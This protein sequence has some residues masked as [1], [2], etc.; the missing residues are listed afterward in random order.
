MTVIEKMSSLNTPTGA[1]QL[2]IDAT[3]KYTQ[4][5]LMQ[6]T[7]NPV[8]DGG[9]ITDN[10]RL[11]NLKFD[12]EALVSEAP[13]SLINDIVGGILG[14]AIGT[15]L[16]G[17][18]AGTLGT[19][20]GAGIGAGIVNAIKSP[21]IPPNESLETI[22]ANRIPGDT[23]YPNKV[24]RYLFA[25]QEDRQLIRITTR[26]GKL[27]NL[28]I[29][30]LSA[31]QEARDGKS[32]RFT[33]SCEQ[34][35]IVKSASITVPESLMDKAAGASGSSKASFGKQATTEATEFQGRSASLVK[36]LFNAAGS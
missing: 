35:Q 14:G 23:D 13:L 25:L 27:D 8:E 2:L 19:A 31:P 7:K 26:R 34:V 21:N 22:V 6:I 20:T 9:N 32:L 1:P 4:S 18:L 10:A 11:D 29:S 15:K 16:G 12:I 36:R 5:R 24:H 28:L 17:G 33:M 30:N 3:I